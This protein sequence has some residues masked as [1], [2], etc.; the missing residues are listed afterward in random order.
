MTPALLLTAATLLTA[1]PEPLQPDAAPFAIHVVDSGSGR[2]V[3]LVELET[4]AHVRYVTDSSGIAAIDDARLFDRDVFFYIHSHGYEFPPDGFGF[5]GRRVRVVS[6]GTATLQIKRVNIAERLYRVTGADIYRDTLLAGGRP[7]ISHP[8]LNAGVVGSDSVVNAVFDGRVY[9]FW[10]DTNR[11]GYPL[12]CFHVPGATSRLPGDGG[13]DADVGVDLDYFT[14]DDGFVR[15]TC[16]MPGDGPTWIDGLTVV[17]DDAGHERMFAKYVKVRKPLVI[18]QR[19]LVE[20][21]REAS[22]FEKRLEYADEAPIVP[23]GHPFH[24]DLDGKSYVY[25]GRDYPLM[26]VEAAAPAL[27]DPGRYEAYTYFRTGSSRD[28]FELARDATGR[29]EWAWRPATIPPDEKLEGELLATGKLA[30]GEAY[31]VLSDVETGKHVAVHSS[32]VAYDEYLGRWVMIALQAFGTSPLGEVWFATA[33]QP[34]GPWTT[35]RKVVTHERY[36]FYNPKQ[37]PMFAK[38]G[39]RCIYFEGTYS[40]TFSGNPVATPRYDYNQVMYRLDL[41][42]PRLAPELFEPAT[43]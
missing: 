28:D 9:W 42:D 1:P 34:V 23:T 5:A 17:T 36:S 13:L 11:D 22:R 30:A 35:A 40:H 2:G 25:F 6:G 20:F 43:P 10:G 39:G 12:G 27:L 7:P 24:Y 33:D 26:R 18:Y 31:F 15:P 8:L 37:H 14:D 41:A 29:L 19:G 4:V 38:D 16:Q 3:P 21:N 32:S